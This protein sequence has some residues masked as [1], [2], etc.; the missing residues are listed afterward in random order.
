MSLVRR[1]TTG[2]ST[3]SDHRSRRENRVTLLRDLSHPSRD[4]FPTVW[5]QPDRP[6]VALIVCAELVRRRRAAAR[7]PFTKNG[8]PSVRCCTDRTSVGRGCAADRHLDE[9]AHFSSVS[10][11]SMTPGGS[12][13]WPA[14]MPKRFERADGATR[15]D[16]ETQGRDHE[17]LRLG[18]SRARGTAGAAASA[19]SAHCRSSM[20]ITSGRSGSGVLKVDVTLSNNRKRACSGSSAR[21]W[22]H[23]RKPLSD[24]GV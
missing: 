24:L 9:P 12:P 8:L 17:Q 21:R 16:S 14:S 6:R 20:K 2:R 23:L 11:W 18:E 3:V 15:T 7:L 19:A 22:R 1:S 5:R 4:H 13:S 10:P